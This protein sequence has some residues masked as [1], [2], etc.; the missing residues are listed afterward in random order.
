L[1]K[2]R[3]RGRKGGRKGVGRKKRGQEEKG[4]GVVF[5]NDSR[6]LFSIAPSIRVAINGSADFDVTLIDPSSLNFAGLELRIKGNGNPQ[7]SIQDWNGDGFDDL[8]CQFADD[9]TLW[10]PGDGVAKL[11]GLLI[12]GSP[13]EGTD[14]I[15]FK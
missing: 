3:G 15:N 11:Y 7:C 5:R 4:S 14:T 10:V 13:F 8:V 2:K 12:D 6:P 9:P 1:R